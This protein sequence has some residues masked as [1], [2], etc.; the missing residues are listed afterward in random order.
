MRNSGSGSM[1]GRLAMALPAFFLAMFG[2]AGSCDREDN[3]VLDWMES[4][5]LDCKQA[6]ELALCSDGEDN[7]E[8]GLTDCLDADCE[9]IGCCARLG[10][11]NVDEFCNDGC[12]NDGDGYVDCFDH[13]CSKTAE[14]KVCKSA[15][16]E[17]ED[18][19]AACS[20]GIDN[21]WNGYFDCDDFSCSTST[22]VPFCEGNDV[23][24]VD[25]IDNDGDGFVD[26]SDY[27]CSQNKNVTVCTKP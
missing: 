14:V 8:D 6:E 22:K 16:K 5:C 27:S 26:C 12:D 24:C 19:P 20:D 17:P 7:D 23:T 9:G 2:L 4:E 13:S 11:E 10:N 15:E 3:H 25:G 18:N 21:D 1:V